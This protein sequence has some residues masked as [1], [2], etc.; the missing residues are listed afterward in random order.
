VF[1]Q[2]AQ[3]YQDC[4]A[5]VPIADVAETIVGSPGMSGFEHESNSLWA[6]RLASLR[7]Q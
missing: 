1:A 4:G 5:F 6:I 3:A 2:S 7:G